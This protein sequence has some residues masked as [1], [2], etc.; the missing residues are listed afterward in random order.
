MGVTA[1]SEENLDSKFD[2]ETQSTSSIKGGKSS[3]TKCHT[4]QSDLLVGSTEY[5]RHEMHIQAERDCN[6]FLLTIIAGPLHS[7]VIHDWLSVTTEPLDKRGRK[8]TLW[9]RSPKIIPF[10]Q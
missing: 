6:E 3:Y 1:A 2:R 9:I 7:K 10:N 8:R 5:I 4:H